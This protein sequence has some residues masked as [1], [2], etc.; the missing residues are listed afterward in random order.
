[1]TNN[2][3][4]VEIK[5]TLDGK[6]LDAAITI[7]RSAAEL[8]NRV[9]EG[10]SDST[11]SLTRAASPATAVRAARP[12]TRRRS[13]PSSARRGSAGRSCFRLPIQ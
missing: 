13:L 2:I 3:E 12:G 1:M 6:Q 4:G 5:G 8:L 11:I 9:V 7:N 10:V